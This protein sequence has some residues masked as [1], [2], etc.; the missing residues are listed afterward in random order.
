MKI[1]YALKTI[2]GSENSSGNYVEMFKLVNGNSIK[3]RYKHMAYGSI[4]VNVGDI[5]HKQQTIGYMGNTGSSTAAH[6]H[7]E[8]V[9]NGKY[10]DPLPYLLGIKTLGGDD[11]EM[12]YINLEKT[13]KY[14]DRGQ[15]VVKLQYKLCQISEDFE[16]EVKGHSFKKGFAD[17]GFGLGTQNTIKKLQKLAG[18]E[19]TGNLDEATLELLNKNIVDIQTLLSQKNKAFEEANIRIQQLS[20]DN[21]L[22]TSKLSQIAEIV[23]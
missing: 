7:V 15:D 5:V 8:V 1:T 6:V 2:K 16:K 13:L 10:V 12:A 22:K 21:T 18:L 4:P 11:I 17:G 3:V 14:G 9:I 23:K 19:Q 20:A